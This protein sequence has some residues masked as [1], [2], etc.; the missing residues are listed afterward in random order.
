MIKVFQPNDTI[1]SSNGDIVLQPTKAVVHKEDNGAYYLDLEVPFNNLVERK[2]KLPDSYVPVNYIESSGTQYIDT[3]MKA[4]QNTS[5]ELQISN[6][7]YANTKVF[8]SRSSATSNNFSIISTA[9]SIVCD[10]Y[11]YNNNRLQVSTPIEEPITISM[12]NQKLKLNDEEKVVTTYNTFTTPSNAYI[13][14]GSGS[15]ASGYTNATMR[16]YS[17]KIWDNG[18]LV[19]NYIPCFRKSDYVVGLYDLVNGVF[20]INAGSGVFTYGGIAKQEDYNDYLVSNNILVANTPQGNQAFRIANI[21]K[22]RTKIK[23]KA[24]HIFYDSMNYLIEDSYVV[25]KD[26]NDALDHLNN[27]TSD[28]SPFTTISD[29]INTNSYRCVRKSLYEAIQVLLERWGGH[30]VRNNW[31]IGIYESIGQDNGVVVRYA[32]NLKEI[33]ASYN[34]N[35]VVTKLMPVGKDGILL[36]ALDPTASV[37][38]TSSHQYEIPFT[39][40]ISFDQDINEE[41]YKDEETG[42][43]DED[44]YKQALLDDLEDKGN[45]YLTEHSIPS[46]N[47]TLSANIEKISDIGDT[48]EVIDER[49]GINVFT[50]IISFDY[51]CILEK[52]IQVEFGNFTQQLSNLINSISSVTE[53][54]I[55]EA[56]STI[57]VTLNNEL[58][59]ATSQIWDALSDSYVIYDG[60]KILIVDTL[61]K[62]TATNVIMINNGGIGFSNTGINGTFRSAWTID[63]V[64]NMENI[65]VINLT[66]DL[67]KGGTLKLG[68]NLN[69]NGQI[70]VY[71]EANTLIAE[72][73]KNGLKMYGVDGSY[74]LMN[75][76]VGFAGYDKNNNKIY[77]V[78]QDEFHMKK[79]VIEEEITLCSKM[80]FIPIEIYNGSTLVN[81]GIGLVSVLGGGN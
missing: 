76:Q 39:K 7:Q 77:W 49:L 1:Y 47:Y 64:L 79:S 22:T 48:I 14:G 35:E 19:R 54:A 12:N 34:W 80:R 53:N 75:N 23:I 2:T 74:V 4:T 18:T 30:L 27:A 36:N 32:K 57:Q 72:L 40:T 56:T 24:N 67:I 70:E 15:F 38:L 28:L 11:N 3:G 31:S 16:L 44:A 26:C 33:T 58:E 81:D 42:E 59:Q 25:E 61:P 68:A 43:V 60:D 10:F 45:A 55:Q 17:C 37:Y 9:T 63:N 50:N 41:D 13:F 52:Y 8:G 66:A 78:A 51:D 5:V 69:Q 46:V 73:N 20:Y 21:E 71:D 62:E 29:V 6:F 65:N